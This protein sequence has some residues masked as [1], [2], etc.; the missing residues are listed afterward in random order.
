MAGHS[1]GP[2]TVALNQRIV[3]R[4]DNLRADLDQLIAT[5][6]ARITRAVCEYEDIHRA[7]NRAHPN[8]DDVT[9]AYGLDHVYD[10]FTQLTPGV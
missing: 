6:G 4:V 10:Q 3:T 7:I 2:D 8:V 5:L 9:E 1:N